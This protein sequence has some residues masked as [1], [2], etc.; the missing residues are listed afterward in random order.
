MLITKVKVASYVFNNIDE[1]EKIVLC[2]RKHE[3]NVLHLHRYQ[4]PNHE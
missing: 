4:F 2:T 1:K 3:S